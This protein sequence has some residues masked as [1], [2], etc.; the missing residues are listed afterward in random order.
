MKMLW[1]TTI[2][3][4]F[5][6]GFGWLSKEPCGN[7]LWDCNC[8]VSTSFPAGHA[9]VEAWRKEERHV[10]AEVL[11]GFLLI[12]HIFVVSLIIFGGYFLLKYWFPF[13]FPHL[14]NG[15]VC[16]A[17]KRM[18]VFRCGLQPFSIQA[19][20]EATG[21]NCGRFSSG[22]AIAHTIRIL[23]TKKKRENA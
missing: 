22:L 10:M 12:C 2:P 8:Q 5:P 14:Q 7:K 3:L 19:F 9:G 13:N 18:L 15:F 1:F 11:V 17:F 6:I 23:I 20:G 21:D 4:D 16:E